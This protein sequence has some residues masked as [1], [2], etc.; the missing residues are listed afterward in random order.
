LQAHAGLTFDRAQDQRTINSREPY[1]SERHRIDEARGAG[2]IKNLASKKVSHFQDANDSFPPV[3]GGLGEFHS[4]VLNPE[5][6]IA[7]GA[8]AE[9]QLALAKAN[10]PGM[11]PEEAGEGT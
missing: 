10:G 5:G 3:I 1:I 2:L 7:A 6:G 9:D 8:Y 11:T 4:T